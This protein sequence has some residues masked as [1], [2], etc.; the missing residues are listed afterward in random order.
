M[1]AARSAA[2]RAAAREE[3]NGPRAAV[4]GAPAGLPFPA[5][6]SRRAPRSARQRGPPAPG[7]EGCRQRAVPQG[8]SYS[9][10][11]FVGGRVRLKAARN[12]SGSR[13]RR[14]GSGSRPPPTP[15]AENY[16]SQEA[17]G[18][19]GRACARCSGWGSAPPPGRATCGRLAGAGR[20][21]RALIGCGGGGGSFRKGRWEEER[22]GGGERSGA[23]GDDG[24]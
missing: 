18:R 1:R 13:R 2:N 5:A 16:N 22:Y 10:Q 12:P 23:A 20:Q 24:G 21:R 9:S 4:L 14:R 8:D 6:A 15:A 3:A 7:A 17:A 19:S 11:G